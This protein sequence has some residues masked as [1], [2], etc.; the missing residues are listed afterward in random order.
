MILRVGGTMKH[1]RKRKDAANRYCSGLIF[2][3]ECPLSLRT[4]WTD[5]K[6]LDISPC[7]KAYII[8]LEAIPLFELDSLKPL[9]NL[10]VDDAKLKQHGKD[11]V[12]SDELVVVVHDNPTDSVKR[13]ITQRIL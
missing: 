13:E 11:V 10:L 9:L 8:S 4:S 5:K 7:Q 6:G 3:S 1:L 12:K 2:F